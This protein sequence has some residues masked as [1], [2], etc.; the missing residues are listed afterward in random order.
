VTAP[1]VEELTESLEHYQATMIPSQKE[2]DKLTLHYLHNLSVAAMLHDLYEDLENALVALDVL[3][4]TGKDLE[5]RVADRILDG[6][7]RGDRATGYLTFYSNLP[8]EEEITIPAGT[9]CYAV[10]NQGKKIF[11]DTDLEETIPIGEKSVSVLA[12]AVERGLGGNVA[13]FTILNLWAGVA[14]VDSV[15]NPLAFD[16]GT[17]DESDDELRQRYFDA[18]MIPGRAVAEM[19][20]RHLVDVEGVTEAH[21]VN[22]GQGDLV[23]VLDYAGGTAEVNEDIVDAL[24]AN[25]AAGTQARGC[26]VAT[27]TPEAVTPDLGDS[28]GGEVYFRAHEFIS[29]EEEIEFNYKIASGQTKVGTATIPAGTHRGQMVKAELGMGEDR[30]VTIPTFT[31]EGDNSY[32]ILIGMGEPGYLYNLPEPVS[33]TIYVN[34][35]A[36][37]IVEPYLEELIAQSITNWFEDYRIGERIEYSDIR[38]CIVIA[39]AAGSDH[40]LLGTESPF[41]GINS[42]TCTVVG[43]GESISQDGQ[44]IDLEEDEIAKLASV[45]VLIN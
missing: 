19:I 18:V 12:S 27:V 43:R 22:H 37:K 39:Y 40:E 21:V 45:E 38:N 28:F 14:G 20:E 33:F 7:Q 35:N 3:K 24:E 1:T 30:A 5:M 16:G 13:P 2:M 6:R 23:V 4:A 34:I 42:L 11:F 25:L 36:L 29:A 9:R 15:E 17:E 44:T 8:V 10:T 32:D 26:L 31:Y 41:R